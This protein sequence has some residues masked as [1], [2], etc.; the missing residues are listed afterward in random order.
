MDSREYFVKNMVSR[1]CLKVI[2]REP[3]V[4]KVKLRNQ[5][6]VINVTFG[7]KRITESQ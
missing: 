4:I 2:K 3:E 5:K 7:K 1:R 6:P